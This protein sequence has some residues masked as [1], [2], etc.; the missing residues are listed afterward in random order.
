MGLNKIRCPK[1]KSQEIKE[2][3]CN[4]KKNNGTRKLYECCCCEIFF[5]ETKN[6]FLEG[7]R[8]PASL[9]VMVNELSP[10]QAAGYQI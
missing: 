4:E 8:K 7:L 2:H 1:C 6:T 3:S 10:Q 9:I 5:S